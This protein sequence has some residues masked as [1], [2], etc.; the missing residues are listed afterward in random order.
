MPSW[1]N[2]HSWDNMAVV[3]GSRASPLA[4]RQV[5]ELVA[6]VAAY[7]PGV[8]FE[9][10]TM[11]TAGDSD[12][13]TSLRS[14][15]KSDFFTRELDAALLCG[16]CRVA[17]HSAKDLP[18]PLPAGLRLV[19]L[20]RGVDDGDVVVTRAGT[21]YDLPV[22]ACVATSSPRRE[23]AVKALRPDLCFCDLRGTIAQ[24]LALL[25]DGGSGV[26]G[27]VVAE[28]ALIRLGLNAVPR[29]RLP[30]P[31]TPLQGRLAVV[32]RDDDAAIAALFAPLDVPS[33][34]RPYLQMHVGLTVAAAAVAD[35]A[36]DEGASA[37]KIL[38]CPLIATAPRPYADGDLAAVASGIDAYTHC[39][40]TS[41]SAV[42]YFAELLS[43]HDREASVLADKHLLAVGDGT[44]AALRTYV[45]AEAAV[46]TAPQATAEGMCALIASLDL[47]DARLL[48][49]HA[50]PARR[51][52]ADFLE[53]RGCSWT[54]CILYDTATR[55]PAKL[56]PLR[57]GDDGGVDEVVFTSPSTVDAFVQLYGT[58]PVA[59]VALRC[60]GPVTTARLHHYLKGLRTREFT[61]CT[62]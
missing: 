40:F 32:A 44:A 2:L 62:T 9:I 19:A 14:L 21:V 42:R 11:A 31:V 18:E 6:A 7:A 12:L 54:E 29:T 15:G 5:D 59:T 28:A 1:D 52:I 39:L 37:V 13:T 38:H 35:E 8:H 24:R 10:V 46:A 23:A 58:L 49:P 25:E 57:Q 22:S 60:C 3:I 45:G 53:A 27:V 17:V 26:A 34:P 51:T 36:V 33:S 16:R 47:R 4:L 55:T 48:W 43:Y 50:A 30:G 41:K 56:L 20:T 61:L